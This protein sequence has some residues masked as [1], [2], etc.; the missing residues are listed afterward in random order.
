MV[1]KPLNLEHFSV[2][3][4][5]IAWVLSTFNLIESKLKFI[6]F[7]CICP[8][9]RS[10]EFVEKFLLHNSVLDA[11]KKF[12]LVAHL[13]KEKEWQ[14]SSDWHKFLR[15][16]NAF[17]H[18]FETHQI[19]VGVNWLP[20][21][22]IEPK[23]PT[24]EIVVQPMYPHGST[25]TLRFDEAFQKY[26]ELYNII[27]AELEAIERTLPRPQKPKTVTERNDAEK[28]ET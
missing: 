9:P 23:Q 17:A 5:K 11:G 14:F 8:P 22:C 19:K 25:K 1:D 21:G 27:R 10:R 26:S 7:R 28:P 16:R 2:S 24:A 3:G 13:A 12:R 20:D 18:G 15:L 4:P 6:I